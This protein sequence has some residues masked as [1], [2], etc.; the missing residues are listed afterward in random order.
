[1]QN[2]EPAADSSSV[3]RR[4]GTDHDPA[5]GR[6]TTQHGQGRLPERGDRLLE[7]DRASRNG[8]CAAR[9]ASDPAA[10]T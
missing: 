4:I 7:R 8:V 5:L 1:M 10:P 9:V 6:P 2:D 3:D